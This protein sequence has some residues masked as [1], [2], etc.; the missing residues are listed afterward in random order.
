[1]IVYKYRNEVGKIR[2]TI[3]RPVADIEI[4]VIKNAEIG[5][6]LVEGV[7]LLLGRHT[8]FDK[9]NITFKEN[10]GEIVFEPLL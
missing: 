6:A 5:W 9:F 10:N 2:E 4:D 8:I 1:M 3:K 7:P